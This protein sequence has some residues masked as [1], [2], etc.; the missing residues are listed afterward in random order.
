MRAIKFRAWVK[1]S[2]E[3]IPVNSID[4]ENDIINVDGERLFFDEIILMEYVEKIDAYEGDI[5]YGRDPDE[6]GGSHSTW[7]GVVKFNH[8]FGRLMV[9]DEGDH[10]WYEIDDYEFDRVL[11][12]FWR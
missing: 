8:R 2:K 3:M 10:R 6:F 5:L 4:F 1:K 11:F 9:C 7:R 12:S